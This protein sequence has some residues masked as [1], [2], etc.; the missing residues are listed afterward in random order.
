[1]LIIDTNQ[2]LV[3]G[4]RE[5]FSSHIEGFDTR[6]I[7][8]ACKTAEEVLPQIVNSM[9]QKDIQEGKISTTEKVSKKRKV[10]K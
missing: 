4:L 8:N 7:L 3:P 9:L 6:R 10:T 2:K 1:M 5:K